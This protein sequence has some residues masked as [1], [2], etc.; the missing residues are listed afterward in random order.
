MYDKLS[1]LLTSES[2]QKGTVAAFGLSFLPGLG[3]WPLIE[4]LSHHDENV[5]YR[6]AFALGKMGKAA[7]NAV[8]P[9]KEAAKS[10]PDEYARDAAT[11]ALAT[12]Q[13][14]LKPWWRFW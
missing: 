6:A 14:E 2:H 9:L 3:D 10:D 7:Y 13:G 5:R 4:A 11:E 1:E 8:E 12:I